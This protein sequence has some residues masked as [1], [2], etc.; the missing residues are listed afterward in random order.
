MYLSVWALLKNSSGPVLFS[1]GTY[2]LLGESLD[3][4]KL[5][6]L[7]GGILFSQ[8]WTLQ[9]FGSHLGAVGRTFARHQG[10]AGICVEGQFLAGGVKG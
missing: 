8:L 1:S 6:G 2:F 4:G 5:C 3:F 9:A 10:R 7:S